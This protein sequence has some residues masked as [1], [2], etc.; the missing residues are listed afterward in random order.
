MET[1]STNKVSVIVTSY[2]HEKYIEQ[3]IQSIF[4]QTY[5]NIELIIIDDG[6]TD[7]SPQKINK[8]VTHSPFEE[9]TVI[10]QKNKGACVSRNIGLDKATGDFVLMVDSDNYLDNNYVKEGVTLLQDS[11]KDIAYYSLKFADTGNLLNDVP[12]YNEDYFG[13]VNYIDTC[14]VIR[15]SIIKNHRFD[16]QLNRLFMQDYDFFMGLIS[17][18]ARP[19]KVKNAFLNYRILEN[20]VGNRGDGIE[21]RKKW[22]EVYRYIKGKYPNIGGGLTID[23]A[24][25]YD[26][27]YLQYKKE[28]KYLDNLYKDKLITIERLKSQINDKETHIKN[29]ESINSQI[30]NS[31][32]WLAGRIVTFPV[33][34]M[35][36]FFKK[37]KTA[38]IV[39]RSSGLK[40][41]IQTIKHKSNPNA[42]SYEISF[43]HWIDTV[44]KN[45]LLSDKINREQFAYK[46]LISIL[47]PTY[48]VDKKWLQKCIES[49]ENQW[50]DNWE[51]CI[52]DDAST[53]R[54]TIEYLKSLQNNSKYHIIFR[55]NN[56][57]ISEATNSALDIAKG[58][59]IAL[60]DN[61]DTL[62]PNA[63]YE[64][65]K[66][67]NENPNIA[68][69]YSDEDKIDENDI[70][71]DAH[72]KP[73]WSPSLILNQNYVS[74]LGVYRTDISRNIG[75]FRKGFEGCQDHD[76]VLRFVECIKDNQIKHI[77]KI[78]Y[79]WR[80]ISTSTAANGNQ[81]EY[82]FDNGIKMIEETLARR[83]ISG[84]VTKGKYPG[85]YNIQYDVIGNPLVSIIIP[86]RN[87]Y[88]DLKKC[89]DSIINTSTYN[90]YEIIIADNGSD[91]P[92]IFKLFE[93]YREKLGSRFNVDRL[94]MPFNYSRINN[95]A[96]KVANGDYYLFL[97]N[98]TTVITPN[99]IE[100]MLGFAQ[101][102][103][104][105]CVGA[106]LWYPDNTIQHGGV[107]LGTGGVAGHTFINSTSND[108]G[109]FSR[110][111][112]DFNYTA[113]TAA[114]LMVSK[115]DFNKVNGF[116]EK[117]EV[118]FND[119]DLCIRV[120]Q[121]GR[122]NVWA[123]NAELYHYES[124]SRGLED[125]PE[126][127]KRFNGEIEKMKSKHGTLLIND[128]AYNIN[129][130][131][132][133][134]PFTVVGRDN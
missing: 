99:W 117:L 121:L 30:V 112:T 93:I 124:K 97:N 48:N 129:L 28:I 132:N 22:F 80:A 25:S 86:T 61:D 15:S 101:F 134:S 11:G 77:P 109:Y 10:I 106:K 115:N 74:H 13:L 21:K 127:I 33:R 84:T 39:Y 102:P 58:E 42:Q 35:K 107:I 91:D 87:G 66:V 96:T 128:P 54:E 64:V 12:E 7:S 69:I 133:H 78:L 67:L 16:L 59:Y 116:D 1:N 2:N 47:I 126:K 73:D 75:G 68:M 83:N 24:N 110:L 3:C 88:D 122:Y 90:N 36:V 130:S 45:E 50:Y 44:E 38:L 118:A 8:L 41:V 71:F 98:D 55:K 17:D 119:V 131:L 27:L 49:I 46:P 29:L 95:L 72:F 104:I 92:N 57:H 123:H 120:Y 14:S 105:G 62:M 19:I 100:I 53:K 63:L 6:S 111:Y 82:A 125:T 31:K 60:L 65:V 4:N 52:A 5:K 108:P 79:H 37:F 34:K 23:L 20:S 56:G 94:D 70:R 81:K 113:V 76:F 9:T 18:G 32:I 103:Q 89:V 51:V 114:C 43:K 85:L 40:G 26:E